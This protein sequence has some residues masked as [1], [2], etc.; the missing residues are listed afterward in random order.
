MGQKVR[1]KSLKPKA[2]A[3]K[4]ILD[5]ETG[6]VL[7]PVGRSVTI[8][9]II[10]QG[11]YDINSQYIIHPETGEHLTLHEA[12]Q[13]DIVDPV[14]Q[15]IDPQTSRIITLEEAMK[16]GLINPDKFEVN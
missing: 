14:S 11:L 12:V 4:G 5:D 16:K 1:R 9:E 7:V 3:S 13:C 15:L 8:P 10:S 6:N 2:A